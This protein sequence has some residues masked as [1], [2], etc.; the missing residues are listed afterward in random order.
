M[1]Q[2]LDRVVLAWPTLGLSMCVLALLMG[3]IDDQGHARGAPHHN[4]VQNNN[5]QLAQDG[6]GLFRTKRIK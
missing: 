6:A 2:V 1:A 3:L 4:I 5:I